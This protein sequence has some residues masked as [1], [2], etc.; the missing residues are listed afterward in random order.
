M[1]VGAFSLIGA[2]AVIGDDSVIQSHVV[3]ECSVKV[4]RS[5]VLGHGSIIGGPPQ[6][7]AFRSETQSGVVIG[8]NNVIREHCTIHR[9]TTDG[10]ATEI[11]DGN[12]LMAGVH[13]GHNCRIGNGVI[14]ANNC[15]LGGY[16]RIDDHAFIG[17]GTTFHQNVHIGRLVM[18]Q[19]MSGFGKDVPPFLLAGQ[20]N[21]VFGVNVL[22]LRR[23]GFDAGE[24][25]EIKRAFKLLYLSGWNV[26]QAVEAAAKAEFG[27][28]GREFFGFA[29]NARKRGIVRYPRAGEDDPSSSL[30]PE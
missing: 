12:F 26:K 10:S 6:D 29:Q 16:V 11:G 25:D 1:E 15:L 24:R 4:G 18:T 27:V 13:V 20:R 17:G 9:G 21:L 3:I 8:D 28:L 19:G 23:T 2:G 5:N 7:L 30:D 14:L 22:G